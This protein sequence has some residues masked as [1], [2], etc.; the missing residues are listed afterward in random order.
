[1]KW[2]A[3]P[4]QMADEWEIRRL[5][6]LYARAMD[7]NDPEILD[8]I[9]TEDGVIDRAGQLR[10]GRAA[11]RKAPAMLNE[12]YLSTVH[13]VHNQLITVTGKDTAEG[14]TYCHAEHLERD[15]GG[16][17]TV[18]TMAIRYQDQ[19][20]RDGGKWRFK[21]RTLVVEWTDVRSVQW[22]KAKVLEALAAEKRA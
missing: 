6:L 4:G 12:R 1:M 19:Y 5:A 10:T 8:E 11:V 14:E 2:Q 15:R 22:Q 20:V 17:N 9:F 21:R 16:G 7:R 18:Y 13:S 3:S